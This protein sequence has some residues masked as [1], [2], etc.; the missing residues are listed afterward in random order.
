MTARASWSLREAVVLAALVLGACT[1]D[2]PPRIDQRWEPYAG[3]TPYPEKRPKIAYPGAAD[4]ALVP[5]SGTDVLTAI[6]LGAGRVIGQAPVGR[7]PVAL[8]G[9]HQVV[10]ERQRRVAW[11]VH[12]YPNATE[13]AGNHSHGSSKVTGWVQG[14][15]LDDLHAMG[16]VQVDPNPG[17]IAISDDG[18]RL[19]VTHFDLTS[20]TQTEKTLDQRRSTLALIDPGA[21][22]P[23]GTPEP[24]KLLVCVAPHGLAMSR[25]DGKTAFVACYGE[26]AVAIVDLENVTTPIVR[27]P[28]GPAART[29][30]A[31]TYGPYGVALSPNGARLAIGARSSNEVRFLDVAKHQMETLVASLGGETYVP[32]W[33]SDGARLFVPTRARDALAVIDATSGALVKQRIFDAATCSAPI[34]AIVGSDPNTVYVVCEGTTTEPGAL[35]AVDATTLEPKSRVGVGLFPGRPFVGRLP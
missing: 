35:L 12:A 31:P 7:N 21:V 24:D 9:P 27:V 34:E 5:S 23:F 4:F 22:L 32:A 16:E 1:K 8:D 3:P 33:S 29:E 14:Y 26:D 10:F 11:I 15:A 18:K 19:V 17:E 20:A 25:P 30:G 2:E 6:D 13:S 28:L